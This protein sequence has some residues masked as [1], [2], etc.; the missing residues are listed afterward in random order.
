MYSVEALSA[1]E[2]TNIFRLSK[3]RANESAWSFSETASYPIVTTQEHGVSST[4]T[5]V[6]NIVTDCSKLKVS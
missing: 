4:D 5:F 2:R 3:S 1:R 6:K